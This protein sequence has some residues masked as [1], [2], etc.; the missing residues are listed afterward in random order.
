MVI[1]YGASAT[2]VDGV[3]EGNSDDGDMGVIG[4]VSGRGRFRRG[5]SG[6]F[7]TCDDRP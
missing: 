6:V 1:A 7:P 4:R 2:I 3:V 5:L